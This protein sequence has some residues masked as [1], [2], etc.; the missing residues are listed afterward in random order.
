MTT[1]SGTE[2][3]GRV[4]DVLL[5]FTDGPDELGV[6]QIA[7]ELDLSKAVVH[8]ILQT[9]TSRGMITLDP[10]SRRYRLGSTTA[11]L[12]ARAL[13]GLDLRSA[14]AGPLDRL[15]RTTGE[16]VTLSTAVP[17]GRVYIEQIVSTQEVKMTVELGRRF[18]LHA[19]SSG[20]CIL[21]FL[22]EAEREAVLGAGLDALTTTTPTDPEALRAELA[23]IRAC[24][25]AASAGERQ[26][27]AG[28]VAA[29][30]FGLDGEVRGAVSVCGPRW[31]VTSEFVHDYAGGVVEAAAEVSTALGW[32]GPASESRAPLP[33]TTQGR[34]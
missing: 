31:R 8:R 18:P 11:A 7:R 4:I 33:A 27:D 34:T 19:G 29:P 30:V 24:G 22:P 16:T 23:E 32:A 5:L 12:G 14:A 3:A 21:A 20:K 26:A 2:T 17:G 9:L 1:P 25:F 10:E 13:R 6:S 15:H 28:S